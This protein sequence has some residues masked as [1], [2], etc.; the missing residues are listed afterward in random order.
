MEYKIKSCAE[1]EKKCENCNYRKEYLQN[2]LEQPD[3]SIVQPHDKDYIPDGKITNFLLV[4]LI[5]MMIVG[6]YFYY[7]NEYAGRYIKFGNTKVRIKEDSYADNLIDCGY[8][9]LDD[10]QDIVDSVLGQ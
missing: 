7:Q 5:L 8:L 1:C 2:Q 3:K 4:V 6:A 10:V 9:S